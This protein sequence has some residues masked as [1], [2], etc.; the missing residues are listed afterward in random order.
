M[1]DH[2]I[3]GHDDRVRLHAPEEGDAVR[4]WRRVDHH[5]PAAGL[6]HP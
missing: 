3:R 1:G 4:P 5:H 2:V 6:D